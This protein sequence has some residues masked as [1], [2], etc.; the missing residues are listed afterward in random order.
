MPITPP[1]IDSFHNNDIFETVRVYD[2][3]E[4]IVEGKVIG[5]SSGKAQWECEIIC[6]KTPGCESFGFCP[7]DAC[8]F[9]DKIVN[10]NSP[11]TDRH[12]DC[13]T[14]FKTCNKRKLLIL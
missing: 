2:R 11:M 7:G 3:L 4:Q 6:D 5:Q 8:Y 10:K 14:V 1:C 9:S 13:Y 12:N